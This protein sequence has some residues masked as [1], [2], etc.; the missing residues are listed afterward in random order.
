L[1]S[2]L[3]RAPARSRRKAIALLCLA[4]ALGISACGQKGPLYLPAPGSIGKDKPVGA[5]T[6]TAPR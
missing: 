6:Q 5:P 1:K 3:G 4:G 2:I